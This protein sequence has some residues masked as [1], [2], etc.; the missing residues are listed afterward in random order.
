MCGA[1]LSSKIENEF[2]PRMSSQGSQGQPELPPWLETLRAGERPVPPAKSPSSFSAADL[3]E[4][5]ALPSWMRADHPDAADNTMSNP[6]MA[7]L[8]PSSYPAPQ[9]DGDVAP[10]KGFAAKSLIDEKSLPSWMQESGSAQA[11][12][13]TTQATDGLSAASLV[14]PDSIP[15][16][17][18]Q[19][20]QEKNAAPNPSRP[21]QSAPMPS[22][23][24]IPPAQPIVS[25][26]PIPSSQGFSARDL[27]DPQSLPSWMSQQGGTGQNA[28][29]QAAPVPSAS[30]ANPIVSINNDQGKTIGQPGAN[31]S[32]GL[33]AASLL[34]P[35]SLPDWLRQQGA[36]QGSSVNMTSTAS[37]AYSA[38]QPQPVPS[39]QATP[40]QQSPAAYN[41]N[42]FNNPPVNSNNLAAASLIDMN[43]L[44][45]WL[46]NAE[47]QHGSAGAANNPTRSGSYGPPPRVDNVRVPNRPRGDINAPE[48]SEVAANVFASMLGVASASPNFPPSPG[49]S[50]VPQST[51][52]MERPV[53]APTAP[54]GSPMGMPPQPTGMP[55]MT[56][57]LPDQ[58]PG[59][60]PAGGPQMPQ[61]PSYPGAYNQ[62]M[63]G[64][65]NQGYPGANQ[66]NYPMGSPYAPPSPAGSIGV[67]G[68]PGAVG[69]QRT[70]AKPAKRGLFD[71]IQKLFS[72]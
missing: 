41:N 52:N 8:R 69:E 34:D 56:G 16:W 3:I 28:V 9:T 14:Q 6:R 53:A 46:R 24:P 68:T 59:L 60:P 25:A 65:Y 62:S 19:I 42:A 17:M 37:G 55:P 72:R 31:G 7:A 10:Q 12:R 47:Q 15:D 36:G 21:A 38:A 22:A 4:D 18:K 67:A 71:A 43:A 23:Q 49:A 30:S 26:P 33:S 51:P 58:R 66:M 20:Q 27:V 35:N 54:F 64:A 44:P 61:S 40:A 63:P 50:A 48:G 5:G 45:D 39:W 1:P 13:T 57:G 2:S 11:T 70:G 29:P 32:M